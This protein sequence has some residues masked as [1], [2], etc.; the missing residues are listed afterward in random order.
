MA[1]NEEFCSAALAA[2]HDTRGTASLQQLKDLASRFAV[3][4][5]KLERALANS[6][7]RP[8]QQLTWGG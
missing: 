3:V 1:L 5:S 7:F 4:E 8:L 2:A 6:N